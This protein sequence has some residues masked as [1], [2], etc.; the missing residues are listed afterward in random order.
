MDLTD[1]RAF[2]ARLASLLRQEQHAL[3]DFLVALAEFDRHRGWLEL[4]H[5]GLFPFLNRELGLSK[6]AS[7]F[8][9]TAAE[10]IQRFPEIVQPLRDGRLCLTTMASLS[11]VLTPENRAEV[12]PR[13]FHRSRL[14]AK[15]IAAELCPD[16]APPTRTVVTPA[17]ARAVPMAQA[18]LSS[19]DAAGGFT[20][21][22]DCPEGMTSAPA[23]APALPA[24]PRPVTV[25]PL[26]AEKARL[27]MTVS[28]EFLAK[29]EAARLALSHSLPGATAEDVLSAGLDLLLERDARRKGLTEHPRLAPPEEAALPGAAYIPAAVRR[30]VWERD[31]AC[32]QWPL[33][34]GG[35]CGSR[36]RLEF[37]HRVS[38]AEGGRPTVANVR[39]LCGA[40]NKLAARERLGD[41]LMDR[42]CRAPR[43]REL[44]GI[45]TPCAPES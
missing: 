45:P 35:V 10:L 44:S 36:L 29:L 42:Y 41:R 15:A 26:T 25:E 3:A 31:G 13:F 38:R 6:T 37:D 23:S 17:P 2:A 30:E 1:S 21:K 5:S 8:R 11:K 9:K 34:S 28:P 20:V 12:L 32:C 43:Q 4:G 33:A 7:F 19:I 18:A 16:V 22:P 39:V 27:H 24:P 40:H 14:E